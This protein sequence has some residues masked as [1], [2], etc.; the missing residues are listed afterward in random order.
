M[1]NK[2]E[3]LLSPIIS[4]MVF[5]RKKKHTIRFLINMNDLLHNEYKYETIMHYYYY[6][7]IV[8]WLQKNTKS[9]LLLIII[10]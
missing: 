3:T 6:A 8:V 7:A 5:L 9:P 4:F 2:T 1:I 10:S